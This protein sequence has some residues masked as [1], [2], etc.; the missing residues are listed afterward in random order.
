MNKQFKLNETCFLI[1]TS[2]MLMGNLYSGI[3]KHGFWQG[4]E[5]MRNHAHDPEL[6][7]ALVEFF[8]KEKAVTIV[9]FGCGPAKYVKALVDNKFDCMGYDGNPNTHT[10]SNGLAKVIDLAVPFDFNKK[11]DWVL[12][13]EV[14]EHL[15][16]KYEK[17]FLDNIHLH[18]SK[19]IVL[20]WALR[21]QGGY[22]HFNEKNNDEVKKM[23]ESYGYEN[24]LD[25]EKYLRSKATLWWFKNT[26]MVFR[27]K[28]IVG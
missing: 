28:V 15:P 1:L 26:I 19:G 2:L 3:D 4:Q 24:D 8:T 16:K 7:Q 9:D 25:A 27:K 23:M 14:G 10:I 22:G 17:I 13:L 6:A 11:F 18:N 20:S 21:G 12:C 5:V